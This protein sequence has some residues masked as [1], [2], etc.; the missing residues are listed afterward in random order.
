MPTQ[1]YYNSKGERR[2]GTTWVLGQNLGWNKDA[3]M[4]WANKEGLA[5]RSIRGERTTAAVAANIGTATHTMIEAHAQGWDPVVAAGSQLTDLQEQDQARVHNAFASFKQWLRNNRLDII[6]TEVF[7][8]DEE[9]QTGFC[10]D[11]LALE[12]VE[13]GPPVLSLVDWKS[14]KAT[15]SDHFIQVAAYT[16]FIENLI[17]VHTGVDCTLFG[18]H[19]LR[20]SKD[21]GSWHHT[22]WSR[23]ILREGW[24]AFTWCRALHEI[25]PTIE[26][27]VR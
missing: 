9:Y 7:G 4:G 11:A 16:V 24:K 12:Q 26:S 23:D 25:R 3:L 5:G 1:P 17:R 18:A 13:E 22:F 19:V 6:A 10:A 2:A 27:Y 21:H 20:V 14:S 8:V 15:Y